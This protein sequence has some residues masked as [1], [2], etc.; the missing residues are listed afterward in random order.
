MLA[1]WLHIVA[2]DKYS[3]TTIDQK[4]MVVGHSYLPNDRDFGSIETARRKASH[5]YVPTDW[6]DLIRN[7]RRKNPFTVTDMSQD[8]FVSLRDL[9][10]AFVNR[11][12]NTRKDKVDWLRIRWIRVTKDEPLQFRYRYSHNTVEQWKVVNLKRRTK[13]RPPDMGRIL[14]KKL[15]TSPRSIKSAKKKDLMELLDYV[16]PIYHTFYQDIVGEGTEDSEDE[17]EHEDS[18]SEENEQ[19]DQDSD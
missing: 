6:S 4:F 15:Y 16:P 5:L 11:K 17:S 18:E 7:C 8:D 12:V 14:P 1:L 13:G 2:S 10:K 3:F 19:S 9:S